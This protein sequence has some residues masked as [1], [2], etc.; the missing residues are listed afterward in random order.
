MWKLGRDVEVTEAPEGLGSL[1][2]VKTCVASAIVA[3]ACV[4]SVVGCGSTTTSS[5]DN[6]ADATHT[7]GEGS[8]GYVAQDPGVGDEYSPYADAQDAWDNE[9]GPDW[10]AFNDAY[11]TGWDAGC[12]EAFSGSPDGY[13]YDQGEQFSA[14]D[15]YANNPGDA[16]GSLDIPP[17]VPADPEYD[18][19]ELGTHDGCVS[20]F[21]DLPSDGS[22]FYG[23]DEYDSSICP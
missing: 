16:S 14:E 2:A 5:P 12:D 17:Y 11:A 4:L 10:Q 18:G 9:D 8:G 20:A 1:S 15:C 19:E 7:S 21:D 22:L 6:S 3:V 13:L 23:D